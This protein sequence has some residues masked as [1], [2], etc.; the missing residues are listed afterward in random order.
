M[1]KLSQLLPEKEKHVQYNLGNFI[2]EAMSLRKTNYNFYYNQV[3]YIV[4]M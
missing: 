1:Y 3:I 4:N 2:V